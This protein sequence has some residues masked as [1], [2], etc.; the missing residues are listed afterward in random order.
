MLRVNRVEGVCR[1][2]VR[3]GAEQVSA[4]E[5]CFLWINITVSSAK[6]T[7]LDRIVLNHWFLLGLLTLDTGSV[8]GE[9]GRSQLLMSVLFPVDVILSFF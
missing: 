2:R 6:N 8:G 4:R 1:G 3:E 5:S 7:T 9:G